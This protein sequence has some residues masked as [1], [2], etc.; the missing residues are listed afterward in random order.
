MRSTI[1]RFIILAIVMGLL[2]MQPYNVRAAAFLITTNGDEADVLP[3]DGV[4]ATAGGACTLRAAIQTANA[5]PGTDS[6]A[7]SDAIFSVPTTITLT[8]DLPTITDSVGIAG[9]NPATV[10]IDGANSFRAGFNVAASVALSVARL[11]LTHGV[12]TNGGAIRNSGSVTVYQVRFSANSAANYGGAIAHLSGDLSV[13]DSLIDGN[14]AL[15][16]GGIYS[17]ATM[18]IVNSTLSA[19]DATGGGAILTNDGST[20]TIR[21]ST[22]TLN[23]AANGGGIDVRGL[24][25]LGNSI[26]AGNSVTGLYA[27]GVGDIESLGH[28]AI[29]DADGIVITGVT[30]G[31]LLDAAASPLNLGVLTDNG[32]LLPTHALT[33]GSVAIGAGSDALALNIDGLALTTD[34]RGA[35]FARVQGDRVD[36]GAHE[37][38]RSLV[39]FTTL[40]GRIQPTPNP[41]F[42]IDAH[43]RVNRA[44]DNALIWSG[45]RRTEAAGVFNLFGLPPDVYRIWVKG[46]HT[47]ARRSGDVAVVTNGGSFY[48]TPVLK[49]GDASDDNVINITDFSILAATFGKSSGVSG[50]DARADFNGD[51]AV[52]IT[53]FSLLAANFGQVGEGS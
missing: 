45:D 9:S 53:D 49:E 21:Q 23:R 8:A 18:T 32:G 4:C 19:N 3:A 27:D 52:N 13:S 16:G 35:G 40:Q 37:A 47:L 33:I 15:L 41:S 42:V 22:I 48:I 31:N 36:M 34:Q 46:T 12:G 30:T 28:N 50:Y 43:V 17:Q 39:V 2:T 51:N 44:G 7:F 20:T 6:I 26:V 29:G 11:T 10:I 38:D 1:V 5:V 14:E 25:R 24:L